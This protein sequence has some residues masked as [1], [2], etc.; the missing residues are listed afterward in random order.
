MDRNE[1]TVVT[2]DGYVITKHK[3]T[4]HKNRYYTIM[5]DGK[6]NGWYTYRELFDCLAIL[7]I[8]EI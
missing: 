6:N 1:K 3:I 8:F 4:L 7:R 2:K 5:K